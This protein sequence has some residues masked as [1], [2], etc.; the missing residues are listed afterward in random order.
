[1][2]FYFE[3]IKYWMETGWRDLIVNKRKIEELRWCNLNFKDKNCAIGIPKRLKI[4]LSIYIL[5][6]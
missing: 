2:S 5:H 3:Q 6:V 4:Q 1:M